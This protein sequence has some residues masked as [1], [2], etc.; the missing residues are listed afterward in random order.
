MI[1][2]ILA[3]VLCLML[4]LSLPL[5]ALA[6]TDVT[7]R[8][9]PGDE[10]A[11]MDETVGAALNSLFVHVIAADEGAHIALE[12]ETGEV[13]SAAVG[14]D[15]NGFY[16]SSPLLGE[17]I[18]YFTIEDVRNFAIEIMKQQGATEAELAEIEAM[19]AQLS[20][21]PAAAAMESIDVE[22][23]LAD[24]A[25]MQLITS[26]SEKVV[27]TEGEFTDAAHDPATAKTEIVLTGDDVAP[28][29][30]TELMK[31][32]YGALAQNMGMD[33]ETMLKQVK[34]MLTQLDMKYNITVF[35]NGDELCA[36][37][38]DST[39][40]GELTLETTDEQGVATTETSK[41]DTAVDM[42]VNVLTQS[43]DV[44][45]VGILYNLTN[46]GTGSD[47][48]KTANMNINITV[49]DN[50]DK[51]AFVGSMIVNDDAA[52]KADFQGAFAEGENDSLTGWFAVLADGS[53]VTFDIK[54]SEENDVTNVLVSLLVREEA[55]AIV[56]PTWS[57]KP[58]LSVAVQV[59]DTEAP[60]NLTALAA[61]TPETAVQLLKMSQ[62]EM[63]AEVNAISADAT[64]AL[65]AGL[66]NLPTEL[67]SLFM[68]SME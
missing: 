18:L 36:L 20:G 6:A 31:Q 65:F 22:A 48:M 16:V 13:V 44:V 32:V 42:D 62:E 60:A 12:S 23:L 29:F 54:A 7:V 59:K 57:D 46:N 61:A 49:D 30:D 27:T 35:T 9:I 5:G 50:A 53:Q 1:R 47:E 43:E 25:L 38:M 10:L 2:K 63:Q 33:A 39:M 67:L 45:N 41:V 24:P 52:N 28:V 66:A 11:Q 37:Q 64:S 21:N 34:D 17:R 58:M 8:I 40:V 56:E 26:I 14:G 19:F 55:T 3:T 15:E 51:V 4:A 68:G